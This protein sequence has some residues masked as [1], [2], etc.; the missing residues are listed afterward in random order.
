MKTP[1]VSVVKWRNM[2][3]TI[4]SKTSP[5]L[6]PSSTYAMPPKTISNRCRAVRCFDLDM[7]G[8]DVV[9]VQYLLGSVV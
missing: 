4:F 7:H 9:S 6:K 8:R 1:Y 5:E 3:D 2:S